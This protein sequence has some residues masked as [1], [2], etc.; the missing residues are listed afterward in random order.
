M[1]FLI[2]VITFL[3]GWTLLLTVFVLCIAFFCAVVRNVFDVFDIKNE[4]PEPKKV[5]ELNLVTD[6]LH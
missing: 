6:D 2:N 4:T 1:K 5:T 3:T